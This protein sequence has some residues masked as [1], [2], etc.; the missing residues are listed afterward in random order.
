MI[1]K[2]KEEILENSEVQIIEENN[3]KPNFSTT[4]RQSFVGGLENIFVASKEKEEKMF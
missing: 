4:S 1:T 2:V 3:Q